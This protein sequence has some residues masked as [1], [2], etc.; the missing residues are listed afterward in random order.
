MRGKFMA[1]EV[2]VCF[3]CVCEEKKR[4]TKKKKQSSTNC[5]PGVLCLGKKIRTHNIYFQ[6]E[7]KKFLSASLSLFKSEEKQQQAL[8]S[9]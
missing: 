4:T 5:C 7:H 8:Q 6:A 9:Q 3:L 1:K 2:R